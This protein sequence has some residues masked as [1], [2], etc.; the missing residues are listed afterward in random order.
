MALFYQSWTGAIPLCGPTVSE[1][2]ADQFVSKEKP[3]LFGPLNMHDNKIINLSYGTSL[4]DAAAFGQVSGGAGGNST[5]VGVATTVISTPVVN[6]GGF[7]SNGP[8]LIDSRPLYPTLP[9]NS[10]VISILPGIYS[11]NVVETSWTRIDTA[12]ETLYGYTC[13][14]Y[15]WNQFPP[16]SRRLSCVFDMSLN[17]SLYPVT[18]HMVVFSVSSQTIL[19]EASEALSNGSNS[20]DLA[21]NISFE[22]LGTLDDIAIALKL[23][24]PT[25]AA[26]TIQ[27]FQLKGLY[28]Q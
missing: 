20:V 9:A 2:L 8:I 16:S 7:R 12:I 15:N 26:V 5:S 10:D 25:S 1:L 14:A 6:F 18:A 4:Y 3:E 13:G 23:F 22:S 19:L 27:S 21:R 11:P 17:T 24:V 28:F